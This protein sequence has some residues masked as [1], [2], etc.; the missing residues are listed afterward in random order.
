MAIILTIV[1]LDIGLYVIL[2]H[3]KS[4]RTPVTLINTAIW[5]VWS[6]LLFLPAMHERYTYL[7]DI[8]LVISL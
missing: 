1:I 7:L 6:I 8:L 4:L 3:K 5:S 2:L